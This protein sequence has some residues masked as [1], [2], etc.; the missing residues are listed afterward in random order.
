MCVRDRDDAS[1]GGRRGESVAGRGSGRYGGGGRGLVRHGRYV[2]L[3]VLARH[4][5]CSRLPRVSVGCHRRRLNLR[6]RPPV[7]TSATPKGSKDRGGGGRH[8]RVSE[9][10]NGLLFARQ[11]RRR[12]ISFMNHT[13]GKLNN[14]ASDLVDRRENDKKKKLI[15]RT[16]WHMSAITGNPSSPQ[17]YLEWQCWPYSNRHSLPRSPSH[18]RTHTQLKICHIL[19]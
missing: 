17:T 8:P 14:D 4:H 13:V 10:R 1:G 12:F 11:H 9:R 3:P 19:D 5:S 7:Q 6:P 16:E 18:A 2:Q 15:E